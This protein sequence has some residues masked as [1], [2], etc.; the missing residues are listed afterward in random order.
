VFSDDAPTYMAT[1]MLTGRH[2]RMDLWRGLSAWQ[3]LVA[4]AR[5][6]G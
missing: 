3:A 4:T 5:S 6:E 2:R 1:G